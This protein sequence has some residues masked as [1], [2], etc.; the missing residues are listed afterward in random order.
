MKKNYKKNKLIKLLHNRMIDMVDS[1][2]QSIK[3]YEVL[4]A[5]HNKYNINQIN[6]LLFILNNGLSQ[7]N[8]HELS[9][10]D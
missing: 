2:N 4:M 10:M 1:E 8:R 6:E 3:M 7:N 9:N 5:C